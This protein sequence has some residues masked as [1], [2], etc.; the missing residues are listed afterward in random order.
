MNRIQDAMAAVRKAPRYSASGDNS[1]MFAHA[2]GEWIK[3]A[4]TLTALAETTLS[5]GVAE[6]LALCKEVGRAQMERNG[7]LT[8]ALPDAQMPELPKSM[9]YAIDPRGIDRQ[10]YS[11]EDMHAYVIADRAARQ[12]AEPAHRATENNGEDSV[13]L[14][15]QG[16][17]GAI[18]TWKERQATWITAR[19]NVHRLI[20]K[21]VGFAQ[22]AAIQP[23]AEW[24]AGK[25]LGYEAAAIPTNAMLNR[26]AFTSDLSF[27]IYGAEL[28]SW[29][30]KCEEIRSERAAIQPQGKRPPLPEPDTTY[31]AP[32]GGARLKYHS[33]DQIYEFA[34]A[35]VRATPAALA[36]AQVPQAGPEQAS[37]DLMPKRTAFIEW[38]KSRHLDSDEDR[39]AWGQRKFKHSH[40]EAMWE[41][42]FNAP[43]DNY[44]D[45]RSTAAPA[46]KTE[47]TKEE[48]AD[49]EYMQAYVDSCNDTLSLTL[50]EM[51]KLKVELSK[52]AITVDLADAARYRW[53]RDS[54]PLLDEA[55]PLVC[56]TD[57]YG[58]ALGMTNPQKMDSIIDAA[59]RAAQESDL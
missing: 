58:N 37:A 47:L 59:R 8:P 21:A 7:E 3:R 35:R 22:R 51:A 34:N 5:P 31:Y 4:D 11:A 27:E 50:S 48:L 44:I 1:G 33:T 9:T 46:V 36:A 52:L 30:Y 39:D 19:P 18:P 49:P 15:V 26:H 17:D 55:G 41:G 28:T 25:R 43:S 40:V 42:W 29:K 16:V 2:Q 56:H 53:L 10:V 32:F 57:M 6:A 14:P 38:C 23:D 20:A 24:P 45:A 13:A 12:S 54:A